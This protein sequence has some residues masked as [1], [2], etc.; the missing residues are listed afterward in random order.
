MSAYGHRQ[1][2]RIHQAVP[3]FDTLVLSSQRTPAVVASDMLAAVAAV[4]MLDWEEE[5][6]AVVR[7]GMVYTAAVAAVA[8]QEK[9]LE[10]RH[11]Y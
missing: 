4:D 5:R 10:K 9:D 6:G 7:V 3:R 1:S 8:L 2:W 11:Y